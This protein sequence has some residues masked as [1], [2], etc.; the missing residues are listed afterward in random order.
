MFKRTRT[1]KKIERFRLDTFDVPHIDMAETYTPVEFI[2]RHNIFVEKIV[3]LRCVLAFPVAL[4]SEI[5]RKYV[6]SEASK[7]AR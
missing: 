7:S 2:A 6:A 1:P 5:S 4:G 3:P